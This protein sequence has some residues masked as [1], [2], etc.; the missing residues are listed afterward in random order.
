[1][2]VAAPTL[3]IALFLYFLV[4]IPRVS[5]P[6]QLSKIERI[7]HNDKYEQETN[8]KNQRNTG[9][10]YQLGKDSNTEGL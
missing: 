3:S 1:M 7:K 6:T 2:Q 9:E 4:P 10:S 5:S 8:R